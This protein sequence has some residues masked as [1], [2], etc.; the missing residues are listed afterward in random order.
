MSLPQGRTPRMGDV[1]THAPPPF[2]LTGQVALVTGANHGIGAATARTLAACGARVL[3]SYLRSEEPE[4]AGTQTADREQ[5]TA[6]PDSVVSEI[7]ASGGSGLALEADL[8][9]PEVAVNLFDVA[10]RSK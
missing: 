10:E 9:D 8:T 6:S 5:R 2:D 7:E 1:S 3:L 4:D